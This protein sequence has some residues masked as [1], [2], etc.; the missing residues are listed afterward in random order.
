MIFAN[1]WRWQARVCARLAEDY[2]DQRLAG[3]LS[4][5]VFG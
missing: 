2:E 1:D 4:Y 5:W 3:R